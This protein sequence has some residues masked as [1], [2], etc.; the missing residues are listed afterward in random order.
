MGDRLF[1]SF[2]RS[3][4]SLS[5]IQEYR[6]ELKRHLDMFEVSVLVD[7]RGLAHLKLHSQV[8]SSIANQQDIAYLSDRQK[9]LYDIFREQ[10]LRHE[11]PE[12]DSRSQEQ[13]RFSGDT[14]APGAPQASATRAA[15]QPFPQMNFLDHEQ[16][17]TS[18]H[19]DSFPR[20]FPPFSSI[21]SSHGTLEGMFVVGEQN[22][23]DVLHHIINSNLGNT[24]TTIIMDSNN[25]RS[26]SR[27]YHPFFDLACVD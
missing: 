15:R 25:D 13:A 17:V 12:R 24:T 8:H 10:F 5:K 26:I 6:E 21:Q 16:Y 18:L 2:I 9:L 4:P 20:P 22:T 11:A 7:Y 14:E 1:A 27:K 23:L 3:D 19:H